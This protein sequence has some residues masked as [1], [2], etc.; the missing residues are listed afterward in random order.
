MHRLGFN[1]KTEMNE[2]IAR[3]KQQSAIIPRSVFSHFVGSDSDDFD[4]FSE[5]QFKL[6]D[7]AQQDA[8][9]GF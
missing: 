2:L 7:E 5:I 4:S 8:A 1:P 3:L 6:F 9:I